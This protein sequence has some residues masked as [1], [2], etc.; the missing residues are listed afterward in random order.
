MDLVDV[1][2][3][4]DVAHDDAIVWVGGVLDLYTASRLREAMLELLVGR[5]DPFEIILDVSAVDFIDSSGL[6]VLVAVLKRL[7]HIGGDLVVRA[8]SPSLRRLLAVTRLD[9]VF[10]MEAAPDPAPA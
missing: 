8:P 10:T 3:K 5:N 1:D 4:V 2:I 7:R 6:G 9:T